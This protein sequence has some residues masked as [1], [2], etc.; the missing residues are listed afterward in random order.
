MTALLDARMSLV[1]ITRDMTIAGVPAET[2]RAIAREYRSFATGPESAQ[3]FVGEDAARVLQAL[4]DEGYL[5]RTDDEQ[6]VP[7]WGTTLAG[8][9]LAMATFAKPIKRATADRLIAEIIE[10]AQAFNADPRHLV[11]A[12]KVVVFGSYLDAAVDHLGDVDIQLVVYR[13]PLPPGKN[14]TTEAV[15]YAHASGRYFPEFFDEL[16]WPEAELAA[17]LRGRHHAINVHNQDIVDITGRSQVIYDI[18]A[19]HEALPASPA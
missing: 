11:S 19:D 8:S 12:G 6:G 4:V 17:A 14:Y 15:R 2:A 1:R 7:S 18:T 16:L 10:R 5:Q 9:A 13:R 3:H